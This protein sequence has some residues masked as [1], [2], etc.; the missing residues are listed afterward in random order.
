M[1]YLFA[2]AL[3]PVERVDPRLPLRRLGASVEP[4]IP[5]PSVVEILLENV[6]HRGHLAE[7]QDPVRFVKQNIK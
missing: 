1:P 7:Q 3:G 4:L 2:L 5:P 6:E